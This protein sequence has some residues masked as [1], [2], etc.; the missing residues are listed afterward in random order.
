MKLHLFALLILETFLVI[1][2]SSDGPDYDNDGGTDGDSDGDTDGDTDG[3]SDGDTDGDT[4]G[5][6]DGDSNLNCDDIAWGNDKYKVGGIFPDYNFEGYIDSDG[7]GKLN[8]DQAS[9]TSCDIYKTG[10][11]CLVVLYGADW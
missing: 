1:A 5:D 9:F 7:D 4:D 2:C 3:D 8:Q 10:P 6:S 11:G